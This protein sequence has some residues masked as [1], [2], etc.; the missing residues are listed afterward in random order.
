MLTPIIQRLY[1]ARVEEAK[2]EIL[3][4]TLGVVG[5]RDDGSLSDEV[6]SVSSTAGFSSIVFR[7]VYSINHGSAPFDLI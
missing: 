3:R 2:K 5:N 6:S 1:K 4:D 7:M